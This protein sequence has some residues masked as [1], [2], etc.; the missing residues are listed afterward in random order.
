MGADE[1]QSHQ[2]KPPPTKCLDRI[3]LGFLSL[4]HPLRTAK[5]ASAPP[6]CSPGNRIRVDTPWGL[7]RT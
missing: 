2:A 7:G 3:D 1:W 6:L 4:E 5:D